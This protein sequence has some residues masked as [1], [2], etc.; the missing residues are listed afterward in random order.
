MRMKPGEKR[1]SIIAAAVTFGVALIILLLL[2]ILSL[3]FDRE[4]LATSSIPEIQDEE[5]IFLEPELL[6][7]G[8]PDATR[9]E[10]GQDAAPQPPGEPDPADENQPEAAVHDTKPQVE[11][12]VTNK[13][14]LVASNNNTELTSPAPKISEEQQKRVKDVGGK[15]SSDN[16]GSPSGKES[17]YSGSGGSGV[18]ATGNIKGWKMISCP[19]SKISTSVKV[20][21][22]TV[23]ITVSAEGK[24]TVHGATGGTKEQNNIC[25]KWAAASKWQTNASAKSA[26]GSIT[27][28]I[29]L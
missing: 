21:K 9:D 17:A 13:A 12:P 1:D 14:P 20:T 7:L 8:D 2:F 29:K 18:S 22:V 3:D 5:E 19:T 24:V 15:F 27:F 23:S 10:P 4:A 11:T 25:K 6:R 16:N 28:T 26:S